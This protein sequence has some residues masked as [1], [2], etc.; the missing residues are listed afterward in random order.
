MSLHN[1]SV[2]SRRVWLGALLSVAA[3]VAIVFCLPDGQFLCSPSSDM[4][5]QLAAER[6]FATDNI[7]A[8][9]FPPVSR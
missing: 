5:G 3:A 7:L 2:G 8:G 9:H 4:A 6:S 1:S